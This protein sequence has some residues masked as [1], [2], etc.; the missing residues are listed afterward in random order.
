VA[1]PRIARQERLFGG[2][3]VDTD[4]PPGRLAGEMESL[5]APGER[6]DDKLG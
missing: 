3:L 5:E 6:P 1:N 2:R 4:V